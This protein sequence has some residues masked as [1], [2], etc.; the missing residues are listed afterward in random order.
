MGDQGREDDLP[1]QSGVDEGAAEPLDS[2]FEALLPQVSDPG[3]EV[4]HLFIRR[5]RSTC[6]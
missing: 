4:G 1:R 5:W 6:G 3:T 2:A